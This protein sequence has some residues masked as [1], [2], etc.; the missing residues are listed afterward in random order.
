MKIIS[1][2]N[3]KEFAAIPVISLFRFNG[4]TGLQQAEEYS[5]KVGGGGLVCS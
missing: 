4:L 1:N 2:V 5:M 3:R